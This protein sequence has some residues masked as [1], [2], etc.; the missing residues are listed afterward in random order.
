MGKGAVA[1]AV[2][3]I[4][5]DRGCKP[6]TNSRGARD[7]EGGLA[8]VDEGNGNGRSCYR[9][10][11]ALVV[12]VGGEQADLLTFPGRTRSGVETPRRRIIRL[13]AH[14]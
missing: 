5:R 9:F 2:G 14:R 10:S 3:I 8:V 1:I 4:G 11:E 13:I 12:D 7:G 6:L